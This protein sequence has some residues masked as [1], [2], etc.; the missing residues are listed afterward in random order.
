MLN[1]MMLAPSSP[2]QTTAASSPPFPLYRFC[3]ILKNI[4]WVETV[5]VRLAHPPK[6][7][8]LLLVGHVW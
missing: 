7:Q 4:G 8:P 6:P 2:T 1:D 5:M 3:G